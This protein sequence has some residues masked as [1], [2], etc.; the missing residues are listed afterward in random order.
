[1]NDTL[2]IAVAGGGTGGHVYPGLA[3]VER[4]QERIETRALFIGARGVEEG[5]WPAPAAT[6]IAAGRVAPRNVGTQGRGPVCAGG[7]RG[8]RGA[9]PVRVSP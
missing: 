7:G 9:H 3:V 2:R 8:T 5:I 6:T 1:M 4:L